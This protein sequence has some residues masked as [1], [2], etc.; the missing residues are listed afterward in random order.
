MGAPREDEPRLDLGGKN[1]PGSAGTP[2]DQPEPPRSDDRATPLPGAE[3]ARRRSDVATGG[4]DPD[5]DRDPW[6]HEPVAPVDERNPLKSLG[7]AVADTLTDNA[8]DASEAKR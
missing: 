3:H 1:E 8:E 6:R 2:P 4:D 7:R 5:S